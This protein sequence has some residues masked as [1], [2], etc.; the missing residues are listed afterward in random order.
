MRGVSGAG[1]GE[2]L[3]RNEREERIQEQAGTYK[4]ICFVPNR[5]G[6]RVA[7]V[8]V[9]MIRPCVYSTFNVAADAEV[10]NKFMSWRW[11]VRRSL[12]RV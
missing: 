10:E 12:F 2:G 4:K 8:W 6:R 7:I 11:T 1:R 3:G 5:G 9:A